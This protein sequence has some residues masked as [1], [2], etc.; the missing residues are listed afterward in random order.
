MQKLAAKSDGSNPR[1]SVQICLRLTI[2][3]RAHGGRVYKIY[4]REMSGCH[5]PNMFRSTLSLCTILTVQSPI[6]F[7]MLHA[8]HLSSVKIRCVLKKTDILRALNPR[9]LITVQK[10][11][12]S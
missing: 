5:P 11:T 7:P 9:G 6:T 10:K 4:G 8:A 1:A 2:A 12:Q 3:S